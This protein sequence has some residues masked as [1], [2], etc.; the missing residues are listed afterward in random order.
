M[1]IGPLANAGLELGN[2]KEVQATVDFKIEKPV[3][4]MTRIRQE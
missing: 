3:P 2:L 4:A 1:S